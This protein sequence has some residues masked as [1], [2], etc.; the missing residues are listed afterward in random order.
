MEHLAI[1]RKSWGLTEKI[2]TG[3]KKIESRWYKMRRDP[4]DRI[5]AGDV[6][7]FKN[8]GEPIKLK[9]EVERVL[10]FSNLTPERVGEILAEYGND[11]GIDEERI[12]EFFELFKDKK[13][14][15]LVFLRNPQRVESFEID[16]KG[17][18]NMVSWIT[19]DRI[20]DIKSEKL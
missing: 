4:W 5:K 2:L 20:S 12:A 17:F 19:I 15:I 8:S 3:N 14:C 6:V 1:M 7:Y 16:K 13:Y 18:G 11:D 9:A 10:Q